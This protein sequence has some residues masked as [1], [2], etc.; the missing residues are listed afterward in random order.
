ESWGRIYSR[1]R[2]FEFDPSV[3]EQIADMESW[4]EPPTGAILAVI[5]SC[6]DR[7]E[8]MNIDYREVLAAQDALEL[9]EPWE[10]DLRNS[11]VTSSDEQVQDDADD[12]LRWLIAVGACVD[13]TFTERDLYKNVTSLRGDRNKGRRSAALDWLVANGWIE[14]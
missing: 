3:D 4:A 7:G 14:R 5:K 1:L 8:V 2:V 11:F 13:D 10:D 9:G 6:H 12:V